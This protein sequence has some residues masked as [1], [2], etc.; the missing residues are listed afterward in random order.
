MCESI[1]RHLMHFN[2]IRHFLTA[3]CL[4]VVIST[5]CTTRV[6]EYQ[7]DSSGHLRKVGM[8]TP[9][10][11]WKRTEEER[12]EAEVAGAMPEAGKKT[13]REYWEW[14]YTNIRRNPGPP[15]W[16]PTEFKTADEMV[17]WIEQRRAARLLPPYD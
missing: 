4:A 13:W 8:F 6:T 14:S 1:V 15:P 11:S 16:K 10:E 17:H 2:I 7:V 3:L 12:I 5:G 9:D